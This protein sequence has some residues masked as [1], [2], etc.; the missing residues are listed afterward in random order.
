MQA[1]I[2]ELRYKMKDVLKALERKEPVT[3]IYH[4]KEKG[5]I[6]PAKNRSYKKVSEHPFFGIAKEPG[7]KPS[8]DMVMNKLR[9]GR[10][11]DI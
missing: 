7:D 6:L 8:V 9:N 2:V 1:T 11:R 3:I 10:Y 4:G 5:I